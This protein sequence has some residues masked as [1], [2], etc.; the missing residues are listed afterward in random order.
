MTPTTTPTT[1]TCTARHVTTVKATTR[2]TRG[3]ERSSACEVT[4][5]GSREEWNGGRALIDS[6]MLVVD[7][8]LVELLIVWWGHQSVH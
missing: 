5:G 1:V 8:V 2:A 7:D 4:E 3:Q 6:M